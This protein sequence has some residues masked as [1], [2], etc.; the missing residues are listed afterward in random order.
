MERIAIFAALRWECRPVLRRLRQVRRE[1][2]AGC[3]V[4][5]GAAPAAEVWVIQTGMGLERASAAAQAVAAASEFDLFLSTG[6]AGALV[7]SLVPGDVTIATTVVGDSPTNR[8]D[9][10][11]PT[12]SHLQRCAD[13]AGLRT[14]LA[15]VLC[16]AH[17]LSSAAAK[18]EA[19]I[20]TGAVAVEMEGTAIAH[21]AARAGVPFASVRAIL[22]R[23][24]TEL[25]GSTPF[26]DP[27][28]GAVRPLALAG[29]LAA[30]PGALPGLLA[31]Q[32]MMAAA[33]ASLEKLFES[34]LADGGDTAREH[35]AS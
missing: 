6:C 14:I 31:L 22:D 19:A 16:S 20:T 35:T 10:D 27:A 2:I 11:A 1:R 12:R 15:P 29:Y 25:D 24:D 28:S 5:K 21:G 26:L 30:H 32:R 17:V 8:C 7:P 18:R 9:T 33:R 23:S 4:W 3:T 13:R 34:F